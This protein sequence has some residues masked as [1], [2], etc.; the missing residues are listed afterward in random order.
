MAEKFAFANGFTLHGE[1]VIDAAKSAVEAACPGVVSCADILSFATR[2]VVVL[3]GLRNFPMVA[4]RRDGTVSLA[5]EVPGNLPDPFSN[6]EKMTEIFNKK[7][8]SQAELVILLG[9][10][11]IG[12]AH[13]FTFTNRLYNITDPALDVNMAQQLKNTCP[14]QTQNADVS[15]DAKV[16][17]RLQPFHLLAK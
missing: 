12:G 3:A 8:F 5:S 11:S 16:L 7:G 6:V 4:G 13:C 2:D 15:K 17:S 1:E 9:A 10:H 14:V